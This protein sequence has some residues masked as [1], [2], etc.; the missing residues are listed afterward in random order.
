MVFAGQA[1]HGMDPE[2]GAVLWAHPHDAGNDFNFQVPQWNQEDNLLFISSGYIAGSR[3]IRLRR[4]RAVTEVEELWYDP[5]LRFTFLN[6]L[7]LGE[8]IYGTSG[9]G[10]TAIMTA[11]HMATGETAWRTR[12]FS[13]ASL[14][15]ADEKVIILEE[16]GTL[17]LATMTEDGMTTLAE[18]TLFDSRSW[19]VPTLVGA[20]LYARDREK[21]V[22][23]DLGTSSPRDPRPD[24]SGLWT[25][26]H[27]ASRFTPPAFSGGRGGARH[28]AALCHARRERDDRDRPGDERAE[29]LGLR[30]RTG[31]SDPGGSRHDDD[32][33]VTLGRYAAGLRGNR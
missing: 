19:T 22:A 9:Q 16:D 30:P 2:T 24:F 27:D 21:I 18:T 28:R 17:G 25:L 5:R 14:L 26:D 1:V 11:T 15:H 6:T 29:G 7:R 32:G 12:G 23:V 8:F 31:S 3:A 10:S 33:P 20:T 4:R 13:R